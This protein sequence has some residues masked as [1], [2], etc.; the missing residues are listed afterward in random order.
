MSVVYAQAPIV[1][2]VGSTFPLA[3]LGG[4]QFGK[5]IASAGAVFPGLP[6]LPTSTV[7]AYRK[8]PQAAMT[9]VTIA[10]IPAAPAIGV[11][12]TT[13]SAVG[14]FVLFSASN[15]WAADSD[16]GR[17]IIDRE[18]GLSEKPLAPITGA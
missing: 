7:D 16:D 2:R 18:P 10:S 1:G 13:E 12:F 15:F 17:I 4:S 5:T 8:L 6:W 14:A 11:A 9:G 3:A